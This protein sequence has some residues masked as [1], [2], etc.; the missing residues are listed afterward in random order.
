MNYSEIFRRIQS[1]GRV[2]A[3]MKDSHIN[4]LLQKISRNILGAEKNIL[5]AN[6][7][8]IKRVSSS[9]KTAAFIDRLTLNEKGIREMASQVIAVSKLHSPLGKVLSRRKRPNGLDIKKISVPIGAL[10]IIYESR[11]DVTSDCA[12]LGLKSGNAVILRGG[13]DAANTNG[14]IYAAI[15]A[16]MPAEIKDTVFLIKDSSRETV[17]A[18]LKMNNFI[19][20]V[21][22]RGG[23]S[24]IKA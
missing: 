6:Q 10:F 20:A 24:L 3:L 12:A 4:A 19:D 13:S 23:E 5:A 15:R 22:P 9:G 1:Q 18:I 11:P 17:N 14:A 7:K 16:S 2:L 8:D 21:I